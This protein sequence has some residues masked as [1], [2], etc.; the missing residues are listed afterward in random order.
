M[1]LLAV[2][3]LA[4]APQPS[5]AQPQ[6]KSSICPRTTSYLAGMESLY[7]G[8]SLTPRRLTELPDG[9]LYFTVYRKIDGCEVPVVVKYAVSGR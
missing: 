8:K 6:A 5:A 9:N 2:A 3:A 7:R 4:A 1:L